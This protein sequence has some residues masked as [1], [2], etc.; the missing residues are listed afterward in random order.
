MCELAKKFDQYEIYKSKADIAM[1]RVIAFNEIYPFKKN[2]N[3]IDDLEAGDIYK[4]GKDSLF[5]WIVYKLKDAGH[6]K[7][8]SSTLYN[9]KENVDVFKKL[10]KIVVDDSVS[11]EKKVNAPWQSIKGMHG[12]KTLAKKII[13]CFNPNI[14][15]IFKTEDFEFFYKKIVNE[16]LPTQDYFNTS[17]GRKFAVLNEEILKEKEK[18]NVTKDWSTIYFMWFLYVTYK[19]YGRF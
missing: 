10:L 13:F 5:G 1:Q 6:V 17:I 2:P 12:D 8:Y 18:C 14:L 9:A 3:L 4:K 7:S 19:S 16:K 15:P 11:L